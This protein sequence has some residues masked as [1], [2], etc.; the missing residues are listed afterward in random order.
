MT[1]AVIS[2][3][4]VALALI[5]AGCIAYIAW[6]LTSEDKPAKKSDDG[7]PDT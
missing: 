2:I 1:T 4:S 3:V 7:P 5:V 6:N